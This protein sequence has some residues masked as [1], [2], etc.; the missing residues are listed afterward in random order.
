[1]GGEVERTDPDPRGWQAVADPHPAPGQLVEAL[2]L[3]EDA[4]W[5]LEAAAAP[6]EILVNLPA[7][8]W[9]AAGL[10]G[11]D[12]DP[13]IDA[14]YRAW[15]AVQPGDADPA[16]FLYARDQVVRHGWQLDELARGWLA[17]EV[18]GAGHPA[19]PYPG[20]AELSSA[21]ATARL[22]LRPA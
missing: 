18:D 14:E 4:L 9:T 12:S 10:L 5:Y 3:F 1:M 13:G 20:L 17:G 2:S 11:A 7:V 22:T 6:E 21:A 15:Q 19:H 16:A 8:L